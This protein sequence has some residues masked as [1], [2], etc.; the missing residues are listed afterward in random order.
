[1]LICSYLKDYRFQIATNN[2]G[3]YSI[4]L[5]VGTY[6]LTLSVNGYQT[7]IL[8]GL[9]VTNSQNA[10]QNFSLIPLIALYEDDVEMGN[11]GWDTQAGW[12]ITEEQSFSPS[13]HA[14][15]RW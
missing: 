7:Q 10:V 15:S 8:N 6:S 4:Q 3:A 11:L 12:A 5:P 1:M 2:S 13:A 14:A 9:S